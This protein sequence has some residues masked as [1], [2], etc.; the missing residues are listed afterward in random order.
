MKP[1]YVPCLINSQSDTISFKHHNGRRAPPLNPTM[2][3]LQRETR[4]QN[5][6]RSRAKDDKVNVWNILKKRL[7]FFPWT[8][9]CASRARERQR[10]ER[11]STMDL[12]GRLFETSDSRSSYDGRPGGCPSPINEKVVA[13]K[14]Q[15]EI[16]DDTAL[17][18]LRKHRNTAADV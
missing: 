12:K 13:C 2:H 6:Q 14:A 4:P 8:A 10:R 5:F 11:L 16:S 3:P 17:Q 7:E 1:K 9:L 15:G 18:L